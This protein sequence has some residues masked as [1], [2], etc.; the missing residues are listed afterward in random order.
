MKSV[1]VAVVKTQEGLE[2]ALKRA[3]KIL[4]WARY[5][6]GQVFIKPNLCSKEHIPGATTNPELLY[7]LVSLLR[8]KLEVVFVGE[9]DGYNYSCDEALTRTG[10]KDLVHK[11]GG[12]IINL[13]KDATIKTRNPHTLVLKDASLPKTLLEVDSIISVPVMK[14]HEF[15]LYGGAIKNLF[16]CIPDKRRIYLHPYINLVL[17]DLITILKPRFTLMDA[18]VAMEGNGPNRGIPVPMNVILAG[19]DLLGVDR[20]AT[21]IMEINWKNVSHLNFIY[22]KLYPE[23]METQILGEPVEAVKRPFIRPYQDLAVK[24]QLWVYQNYF[25]TRLCFG[26]PIF[27][28]LKACM[29]I[30]RRLDR[31]L[32]GEEWTAQHWSNQDDARD[33]LIDLS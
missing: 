20:T 12:E 21:E 23:G 8:N 19:G 10:V 33:P 22:N 27:K 18:T 1:E 13:S 32:K 25:L 16:G 7:H 5:V 31:T 4:R 26:T 24:E 17:H 15:T 30:Y 2:T 3:L 14:T 11:A 6:K 28:V 29:Q 9:S